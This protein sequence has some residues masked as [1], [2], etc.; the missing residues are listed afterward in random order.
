MRC[1]LMAPNVWNRCVCFCTGRKRTANN[2][3]FI[4]RPRSTLDPVLVIKV[5][6]S[7]APKA[8]SMVQRHRQ[9][10]VYNINNIS[11]TGLGPLSDE[12]AVRRGQWLV[13]LLS[14]FY[15]QPTWWRNVFFVCFDTSSL[16]TMVAPVSDNNSFQTIAVTVLRRTLS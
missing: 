1:F 14:C 2:K 13:V 3:F 6:N 10:I 5:R 7:D 12:C 16:S 11:S 15:W 9:H 4:T 8:G